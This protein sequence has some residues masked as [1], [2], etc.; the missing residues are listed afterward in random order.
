MSDSHRSVNLRTLL[1]HRGAM[2]DDDVP[3]LMLCTL[4]AEPFDDPKWVFEPKLDGLRVLCRVEARGVKLISRNGKDQSLQFP[5]IVAAL[6]KGVRRKPAELDGEIVCLDDRGVSS[7][8]KL[9][10]RFHIEDPATIARRVKEYPAY[11]Y[12]FDVLRV[13]RD[14]VRPL[15]LA[16]RKKVLKRL[17]AWNTRLRYTEG[18]PG[19]GKW[20]LRQM[21]ARGGEGIVGKRL[22]DSYHPGRSDTWVKI[23]CSARQEFVIGGFTEPQ[24]TRVGLGALLVGYYDNGQFRYAGKVGTGYTNDVLLDLRKRLDRIEQKRNPFHGGAK[25]K[26]RTSDVHWVKP[27][28]VAEIAFGEWTQNDLLRQ[29]RF[30][31][32]R[33]DKK[34]TQVRREKPRSAAR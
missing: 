24:R 8:R 30:E 17:L 3:A 28:L 33:E 26:V 34:A 25:P 19:K 29:P 21:C 12:L 16:E 13:G 27:Q 5:E 1:Y 20:L 9:Q 14:D 11:I 18:T 4:V 6:A 15:S 23:K 22:D 10:Q 7:F 2:A 31:G 32:L